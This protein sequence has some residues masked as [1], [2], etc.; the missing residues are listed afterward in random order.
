[1]LPITKIGNQKGLF[2]KPGHISESGSGTL[3]LNKD[4][5][6]L[7][8]IKG[9]VFLARG[10]KPLPVRKEFERPI[11]LQKL[12]G[13]DYGSGKHFFPKQLS[14]KVAFY[15]VKFYRSFADTYFQ[16]RYLDR[17]T[18]IETVAAVP[19]MVGGLFRHLYCLTHF[20][21]NGPVI[22]KLLRE[23]ENERQHFLTLI[24]IKKCGFLE[25]I[26]VKIAQAFFFNFYLIFYFFFPKTAHRFVGYLEEEAIKSY[27]EFEKEILRG[28]IKNVPAPQIAIEY[29]K[30]P[31][32]ARLI[33]VVRAIRA[34][35]AAH[36]DANHQ[37]ANKKHFTLAE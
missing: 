3:L 20:K 19:G 33:D 2:T 11:T 7:P 4:S 12:E 14:D 10:Y 23:A 34:D 18:L 16:K 32:H 26:L 30:L 35:E 9:S 31:K 17:A 13:I 29:W 21:D 25:K 24:E 8:T 22:Q 28:N 37:M 1:M 6:K 5:G 36:R 27:E 15:L